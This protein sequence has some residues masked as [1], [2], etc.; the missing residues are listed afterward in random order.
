LSTSPPE[1]IPQ[2]CEIYII[3]RIYL[4]SP[5]QLFYHFWS[6]TD[7]MIFSP[8]YFAWKVGVFAQN[9]AKFC[10][11]KCHR[12]SG[13]SEKRQF[14]F[15]K[16]AKIA[17]NCD[18]NID[19]W[20]FNTFG[21]TPLF[22]FFNTQTMYYKSIVHNSVVSLK[23]LIPWRDSNPGLLLRRMWCPLRHATDRA[24]CYKSYRNIFL[25]KIFAWPKRR[26]H[27]Y[28]ATLRISK[29]IIPRNLCLLPTYKCLSSF[30]LF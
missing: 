21:L 19:P 28:L 20:F 3:S 1:E 5:L 14:F 2:D 7:V 24:M 9:K 13:F 23:N 10:M 26:L 17:E 8:K 29:K 15:R 22:L 11:Q 16:L 18:H 30:Y 6:G 12:N 27:M 25:P 4:L